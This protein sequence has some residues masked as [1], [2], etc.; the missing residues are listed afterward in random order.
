MKR[1][2]GI[3]LHNTSLARKD[4]EGGMGRAAYRF[5]EQ[6]SQA[7]Q[8]YWQV[9]P[10]F[11]TQT[12]NPYQ[13]A[14]A[15]AGDLRL[16]DAAL[17]REEGLITG[18]EDTPSFFMEAYKNGRE[19]YCQEFTDFK[20]NNAFWL[21]D[22]ALF[23]VLKAHSAGRPAGEWE[24][25]LKKRDPAEIIAVTER[26]AEE[27][28]SMQFAQFIFQ[29]Q[30]KALKQKAN[31]AG[32][33]LIGEIPFYLAPGCVE[34]WATPE[35][36]AQ[37]GCSPGRPPMAEGDA[38]RRWN[39]L[40]YDWKHL[41][42]HGYQWWVKR[43]RYAL[44]FFDILRIDM[45]READAFF[46]IPEGG[47]PK[48]GHWEAGPGKELCDTFRYWLGEV[49]IIAGSDGA[50]APVYFNSIEYNGY[51]RARVLEHAF[52][53][54]NSA[55]LPHH[56]KRNDVCYTAP[57]GGLTVRGWY[58]RLSGGQREHVA[59]Y[60]GACGAP[61]IAEALTRAAMGSVAELCIL[62]MQ[63]VLGLDIDASQY[64]GEGA[65]DNWSWKLLHGQFGEK[66]IA[67]LKEL[68]AVYGRA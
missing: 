21:F 49:G 45:L 17:L 2:C 39:Y 13:A 7:G 51:M 15:F 35:L 53:E 10:F 28:E 36:F 40:A 19:T 30:W 20:Y 11:Y 65:L 50:V 68:T 58:G 54:M 12:N 42:L 47:L 26:Y 31:F 4:G 67:R 22:Y 29:K 32:I 61:D 5:L 48:D 16:V 27:I 44:Q 43:V 25:G 3:L 23:A 57:P 64:L 41:Q 63:D 56:Y 59:H 1:G 9:L 33:K 52:G 62:P 37:N 34:S 14:S 8:S 18:E 38:G 66:E 60:L 46:S 55:E 24:P 6:L